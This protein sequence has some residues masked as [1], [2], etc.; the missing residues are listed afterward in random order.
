[1]HEHVVPI[2]NVESENTHPFLVMQFVPGESLQ[3][4]VERE[5]PLSVPEILRIGLQAASGLA[6]AHAQGL[7]HRDVK[8]ANILLEQGVE[9]TYL[10]DFGLARAS[11]DASLTY[12][13]IIAGTPNYMSPEQADGRPMDQRS[14]LFSLGSVLYFMSTGHP[15]FRADRPMAVL[16]RTCHD[17]HRPA[18]DCNAEI[19]D[20]LSA[21]IDRL[22]E[23]DPARR[24]SSAA[25][26]QQA[27][28]TVLT[29]VQ[30]GRRPRRRSRW[31]VGSTSWKK[32]AMIVAVLI[33]IG[34]LVKLRWDESANN[35]KYRM[36]ELAAKAL[37]ESASNAPVDAPTPRA[38]EV[39]A[40]GPSPV[41]EWDR[42]YKEISQMLDSLAETAFPEFPPR[43]LPILPSQE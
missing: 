4:R 13:G 11:D 33:L 35:L 29:E 32:P 6:A 40:V 17:P 18:G 10:T 42:E 25:E 36:S 24:F 41:R 39:F 7:I 43:G 37:A 19:P 22:L 15:P 30:Q 9:R 27:L 38:T 2:H 5:G 21:I 23:K 16:K 31:R 1:V 20:D 26:L 12:S 34:A 14:D 3:T 28:S 8:P